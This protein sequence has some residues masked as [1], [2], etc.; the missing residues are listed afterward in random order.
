MSRN[1]EK[2][3]AELKAVM[4]DLMEERGLADLWSVHWILREG[5]GDHS[6]ETGELVDGTLVVRGTQSTMRTAV[7]VRFREWVAEMGGTNW[8]FVV[9]PQ[10]LQDRPSGV[11]E[12]LDYEDVPSAAFMVELVRDRMGRV[13]GDFIERPRGRHP[14]SSAQTREAH[15][16]P[17]AVC[18][19]CG[20]T[21]FS[22]EDETS[23]EVCDRCGVEN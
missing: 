16:L 21:E 2:E 18:R 22:I 5:Q 11:L 10:K 3:L 23:P 8:T 13:T 1:P 6:V 20:G 7:L 15:G 4:R 17:P 14:Y 12:Y 19:N 9:R